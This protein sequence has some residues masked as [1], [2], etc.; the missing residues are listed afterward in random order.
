MLTLF[1]SLQPNGSVAY[2]VAQHMG[3]DAHSELVA[4]LIGRQSALHALVGSDGL[5][6]DADCIVV[7]PAGHH[8]ILQGG[9]L[10]LL[11]PSPRYVSTPS[12]DI[13]FESIA[14]QF[15]TRAAGIVLS[16]A[17]WDGARGCA[18]L[19][20]AGGTVCAQEFGE[21]AFT[22][23]PEAAVAVSRE[24][25]RLK[26]HQMGDWLTRRFGI[27]TKS[28]N[29][30]ATTPAQRAA[31][32]GEDPPAEDLD[33]VIARVHEVTGVDFAD[34][35]PETLLRRL[36][37]R[38][39]TLGLDEIGYRDLLLRDAAEARQLQ[40][41]FLVSFSSF[42]RDRECFETLAALLTPRLERKPAG[43]TVTVWVP[44]C[45]SGEEAFTL[46]A[47]VS[48]LAAAKTRGLRTFVVGTDLSSEA[49]EQAK[50]GRYPIKSAR[51]A[52]AGWVDRWLTREDA[53][54]VV[55]P[56]L[57]ER[58]QFELTDVERGLPDSLV[59]GDVDVVS[60]RNLLIYFRP[61]KQQRLLTRCAQSLRPDGL[62]FMGPSETLGAP[63][64][65]LFRTLHA[66]FRIH[67]RRA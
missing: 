11:P 27:G 6:L 32:V 14:G 61:E 3:G 10:R 64:N 44:G 59:A 37:A 23:M 4:K 33:A 54:L 28:T 21:A 57:A 40:R 8:G 53:E 2:V 43:S 35:R 13:L 56:E 41:L 22:G 31:A 67:A 24:V 66:E 7:V 45:A 52:P 47:L 29:R 5:R 1:A 34:Y 42:W 49:L 36:Q 18:A 25:Q 55:R 50:A 48:D 51:E 12:V 39:A 20:G 58:V 65:A 38:R 17:G 16:G 9:T 30:L 26:A 46:A 19:L 62:L 15:G 63:A 60:C